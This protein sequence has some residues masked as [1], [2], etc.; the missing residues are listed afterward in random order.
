MT[1]HDAI[2]GTHALKVKRDYDYRLEQ[3]NT[4]IQTTNKKIL[5]SLDDIYIQGDSQSKLRLLAE[6][7]LNMHP[8]EETFAQLIRV[9]NP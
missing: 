8:N 3:A 6:K 9:F 4:L 1:H 5:E 7:I 2:T